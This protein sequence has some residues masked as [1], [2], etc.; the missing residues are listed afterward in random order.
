[1]Y[2]DWLDEQGLSG[3]WVRSLLNENISHWHFEKR[4]TFNRTGV[5]GLDVGRTGTPW[6]EYRVGC[7]MSVG[8][9]LGV[10]SQSID[11]FDKLKYGVGEN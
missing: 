3:D 8:Y 5:Y 1:M 9:S 11:S 10:G 7:T 4:N 2:A 6:N